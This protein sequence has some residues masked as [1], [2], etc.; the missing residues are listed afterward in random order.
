ML[1]TRLRLSPKCS[2]SSLIVMP[3][4]SALFF[5]TSEHG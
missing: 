2:Q 3:L 1:L 4:L 5:D